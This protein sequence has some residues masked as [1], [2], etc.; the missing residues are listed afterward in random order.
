M[1]AL[2]TIASTTATRPPSMLGSSRC[3][4][5]PRSTPAMI[6]RICCCLPSGKNSIMRPTVSAASIVCMRRED[7]VARLGRL[8]R[9]LGGL[10]V[11][12]L[13]DHDRVGVLSER[14]AERLA[15]ARGVEADLALVDDGEVVA[16][17]DL[18]RVLDRDDVGA[19]RAVDVIENRGERR[20]LT[21]A[22]RPG[23]EHEAALLLGQPL[24]RTRQTELRKARHLERDQAQ[25]DRDGSPLTKHVHPEAR[26]PRGRVGEVEITARSKLIDARRGIGGELGD[27]RLEVGRGHRRRDQSGDDPID[28]QKGWPVELQVHVGGALAH[29]FVQDRVKSH[30]EVILGNPAAALNPRTSVEL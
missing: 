26:Q 11:A 17:Q 24:D 20:R 10:A 22:S 1:R 18:D 29:R 16:M 12:Q 25:H 27:T 13:A 9:G 6:E 30:T 23:D 8:Q 19:A 4:T 2:T 21:R 28:A 3:E 15:E 7:E 14:A 5:T